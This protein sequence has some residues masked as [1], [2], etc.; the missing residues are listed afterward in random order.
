[1]THLPSHSR[2]M[3]YR[4]FAA[5]FPDPLARLAPYTEHLLYGP[6]RFSLGERELLAAYFG[7]LTGCDYVRQTHRHAAIAHGLD[8][9]YVDAVI[10]DPEKPEADDPLASLLGFL[11]IL[12]LDPQNVGQAEV[13]AVLAAG[14]G[15][16]AVVHAV[17]LCAYWSMIV[18]IVEGVGIAGDAAY[19][20]RMG[21]QL[22]REGREINLRPGS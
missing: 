21:P 11:R 10:G 2:P 12:T 20:E 17:Q 22:V 16:D 13:A 5:E 15:D 3:I 14:Y 9:A 18:R 4:E 8:T 1:M 19:H 7:A 6:S